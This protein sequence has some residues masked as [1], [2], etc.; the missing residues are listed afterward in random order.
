MELIF[1]KKF[2]LEVWETCLK[3]MR[4]D[5]VASYIVDASV[6]YNLVLGLLTILSDVIAD[7]NTFCGNYRRYRYFCKSTGFATFTY[8]F[9]CC[10]VICA[11]V[12]ISWLFLVTK[13]IFVDECYTQQRN[14][15]IC[16]VCY[17]F[18]TAEVPCNYS[19][20]QWLN[21]YISHMV[22]VTVKFAAQQ[23]LMTSESNSRGLAD[24]CWCWPVHCGTTGVI[25]PTT[26][27]ECDSINYSWSCH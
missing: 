15:K 16:K 3:S 18:Q 19:A 24:G 9:C 21:D 23:P 2:K 4:V 13:T 1:G 22:C 10:N 27:C 17:K 14:L 6:C 26:G 11:H 12:F 25:T 20:L 8:S 7:I 5:E